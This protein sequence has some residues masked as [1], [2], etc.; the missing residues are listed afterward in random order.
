MNEI[1]TIEVYAK[2]IEHNGKKFV[3]CGTKINNTYYKVKFRQ[4]CKNAPRERGVYI[5]TMNVV[6]SLSVQKGKHYVDSNGEYR[7]D[8]DTLWVCDTID[9]RKLTE[10]EMQARNKVT[11]EGVFGQ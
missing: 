4:D 1:Q 11:M 2:Q 6:T 5:L 9:I 10:E 3:V 8:C 7:Q